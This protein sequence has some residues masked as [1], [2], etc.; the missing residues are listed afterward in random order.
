MISL[1]SHLFTHAGNVRVLA[2]SVFCCEE[3]DDTKACFCNPV[4]L[5]EYSQ[6]CVSLNAAGYQQALSWLNVK[7]LFSVDTDQKLLWTHRISVAAF[8][9]PGLALFFV[10]S[11]LFSLF[12][13]LCILQDY[14]SRG[15][16]RWPPSSARPHSEKAPWQ[17]QAFLL[18]RISY[19]YF[20]RMA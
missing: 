14:P 15:G 9:W 13:A 17:P 1:Y 7:S 11:P 4:C 2:S 16:H 19:C 3:A 5:K 6:G 10:W 12:Q 18:Y 8:S 20:D